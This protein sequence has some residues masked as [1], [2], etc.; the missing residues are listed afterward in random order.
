MTSRN[1]PIGYEDATAEQMLPDVRRRINQAVKANAWP[2]YLY[3][4]VGSG[5]TCAAAVLF[6]ATRRLPLWFRADDLLLGMAFGRSNGVRVEQM[7][8]LG[9]REFKTLAWDRFAAQVA[10]SSCVYL[11]DLGIR[12]PTESMQQGLFDLMEWRRG[13]PLVITSNKSPEVI[14]AIYDDRIL[15]RLSAGT[16]LEIVGPDRREGT[17]YRV[18][19]TTG[20]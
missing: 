15:S 13:K 4:P 8:L 9:H 11:D 2:L 16:V 5:K 6:G 12:K 17:G 20:V 7:T 18:Q 14:G 19:A 3:G 10:D 1:R